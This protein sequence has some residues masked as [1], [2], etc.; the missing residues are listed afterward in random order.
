MA[1]E[2]EEQLPAKPVGLF[3]KVTSHRTDNEIA[4]ERKYK[5][6]DG[7]GNINFVGEHQ[8]D[9]TGDINRINING[10]D[11]RS[12][13]T[14]SRWWKISRSTYGTFMGLQQSNLHNA[15]AW[16]NSL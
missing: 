9:D 16:K 12:N 4:K 5:I 15:S 14:E 3:S 10:S 11:G 1:N 6:S 7:D 13:I 2:T 8:V